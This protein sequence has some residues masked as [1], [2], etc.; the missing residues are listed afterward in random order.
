MSRQIAQ[1]TEREEWGAAYTD[2]GH[3]FTYEDGRPLKPQY[4]TRLFDKF[5]IRAGLP[6]MTLH[7]LRP[8]RPHCSSPP[9][10]PWQ[11]SPSGWGA[12]V[13]L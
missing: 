1:S 11:S 2:C 7:G 4:A 5:R 13:S 9:A 8:S 10:L 3:V 6:E 12:P